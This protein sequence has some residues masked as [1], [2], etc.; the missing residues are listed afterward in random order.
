M[1]E[2]LAA[3]TYA[4]TTATTA[5]MA[6]NGKP[7]AK[8]RLNGFINTP[9]DHDWIAVHL[10]AGELY[11]F[12][13]QAAGTSTIDPVLRLRDATG[14]ELAFDDNA[15]AGNGAAIILAAAVSGTYYLDAGAVGGGA[16]KYL[17]EMA[18][19]PAKANTWSS[20]ALGG[21]RSGVIHSDK[22]QDWHA[23]TLTAGQ[24][25]IIDATGFDTTLALRDAGGIALVSANGGGL[26]AEARILFTATAAGTYYIDVGGQ[27]AA[28]GRYALSI[29]ADDV[30]DDIATNATYTIGT[31]VN[32]SI[33]RG[34]DSDWYAVRLVA[35]T[36]YLFDQSCP[37]ALLFLRDGNGSLLA[38]DSGSGPGTDAQI[39]YT[40]TATG[41]YFLTAQL[42][43]FGISTYSLRGRV[44]DTPD[45]V[46]SEVRLPVGTARG[47]R[48]DA[49]GDIDVTWSMLTGGKR[50]VAAVESGFDSLLTLYNEFGSVLQQDDD[51]GPGTAPRMVITPTDLGLVYL[52]VAGKAGATGAYSLSLYEDAIA[53]GTDS[54]TTL[55]AGTPLQSSI[56]YAADTDWVRLAVVAGQ[57]YILETAGLD[58]I[59]AIR[60][61]FGTQF[62][63]FEAGG[64]GGAARTESV[65]FSQSTT[66]LLEVRGQNGATGAYTLSAR[67]DD[68]A[69]DVFTG[70]VMAV[71]ST[72]SNG[73]INS[74]ADQDVLAVQMEA[75]ASYLID[76]VASTFDTTLAIRDGAGAQL[77]FNSDYGGAL[78]GNSR[79]TFTAPA[80]G[81]YFL[82]VGGAGAQAGIYNLSIRRDEAADDIFTQT[83][84]TLGATREASI[85]YAGDR[86]FFSVSLVTGQRFIVDA[87]AI[88]GIDTAL[89]L[90]S[91][92][93]TALASD[94]DSGLGTNA[95]IVGT[96]SVTGTFL[97]DVSAAPG[98]TGRYSLYARIDDYA[99]DVATN[100]LMGTLG[101]ISPAAVVYLLSADGVTESAADQDVLRIDL[102]AGTSYRFTVSGAG[103][104]P[105]GD[106]TLGLRDAA[107]ALLAFNDDVAPGVL[108]SRLDWTAT[109][110][111]AYFLDI[112]GYGTNTGGWHLDAIVV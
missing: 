48:I 3:D 22:D 97:I 98:T 81:T 20:I 83:Q 84:A 38:N 77:G 7:S 63:L 94:A 44:D 58:T 82:D 86:D 18:E 30:A 36:T 69:D 88:D 80:A 17:A 104:T 108:N 2:T 41:T 110:G 45:D 71:G 28:T 53:D 68:F 55:V 33:E 60:D 16:G 21:S 99:D 76:A 72:L 70:K 112:G 111:G 103:A 89:V 59:L 92:G 54:T 91:S 25:V 93:G 105:L 5:T 19:V 29:R 65:I 8:G 32:G 1:S 23:V 10:D 61:G 15:G 57:G 109:T 4:A 62:A 40:A 100:A 102:V 73:V 42:T 85:D 14:V 9:G 26:G 51:S 78:F 67:I 46:T 24:K 39:I 13:L 107:G 12:T 47:A 75:G 31:V 74:A 79:L 43:T 95:R 6:L 56:D 96:A 90:R 37:D 11:R 35:G 52:A 64:P 50:Y 101:R 106:T 66:L 34:L 87:V 49:P 27:G